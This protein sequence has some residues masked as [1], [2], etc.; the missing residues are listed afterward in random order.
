MQ[1]LLGRHVNVS[2]AFPHPPQLLLE[3][4]RCPGERRQSTYR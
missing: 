2:K 4:L 1:Q 3:L